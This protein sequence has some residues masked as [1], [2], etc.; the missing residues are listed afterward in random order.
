VA[1]GP[2]KFPLPGVDTLTAE[3][4]AGKR[5]VGLNR[6][7]LTVD[8]AKLILAFAVLPF[9]GD[10]SLLRKLREEMYQGARYMDEPKTLLDQVAL[11]FRCKPDDCVAVIT[12][13]LNAMRGRSRVAQA[14]A[15]DYEKTARQTTDG[16]GLLSEDAIKR[17][18]Q[19][20][21][22]EMHALRN[23]EAEDAKPKRGRK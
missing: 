10:K 19:V 11:V 9:D 16:W 8:E 7:A 13:V 17:R 6:G 15:T 20:L 14:V 21:R 23:D 4:W 2:K 3:L 12:S 18:K 5:G 1:R 22:R